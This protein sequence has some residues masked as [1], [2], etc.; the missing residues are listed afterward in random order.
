MCYS[1]FYTK[2]TFGHKGYEVKICS[3]HQHYC[4]RILNACILKFILAGRAR[5]KHF[6]L[7]HYVFVI[8][9]LLGMCC[10]LEIDI[11][12]VISM[13]IIVEVDIFILFNVC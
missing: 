7:L 5:I 8:S 11:N 3:T 4:W 1:N 6:T 10:N 12:N 13:S 2:F 9:K